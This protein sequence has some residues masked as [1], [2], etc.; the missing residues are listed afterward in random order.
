[1]TAHPDC[2]EHVVLDFLSGSVDGYFLLW[3]GQVVFRTFESIL[4]W[5]WNW[6][7]SLLRTFGTKIS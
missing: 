7:A 4:L 1:M 2:L 6:R 5:G 3:L